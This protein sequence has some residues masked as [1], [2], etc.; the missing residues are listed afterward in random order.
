MNEEILS[1]I[2]LGFREFLVEKPPLYAK[3]IAHLKEVHY[4]G[5]D[6]LLS[7]EELTVTTS[8]FDIDLLEYRSRDEPL[9][10]DRFGQQG[11]FKMEHIDFTKDERGIV[12][13][14]PKIERFGLFDYDHYIFGK[15]EGVE[16]DKMIR[17]FLEPKNNTLPQFAS[18]NPC[19]ES[20][21]FVP[22]PIAD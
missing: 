1:K 6:E 20:F 18:L 12:I 9:E 15:Y 17:S 8:E 5:H 2:P 22:K 7:I 13:W 19:A 11:Y 14:Y 16:W 4:Y 3:Y 10:C 21:E